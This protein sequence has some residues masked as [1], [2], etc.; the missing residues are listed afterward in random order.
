MLAFFL[1][2]SRYIEYVRNYIYRLK[3]ELPFYKVSLFYIL[4]FELIL[5]SLIQYPEMN[6]YIIFMELGHPILVPVSS[7]FATI[8]L[9]RVYF[10]LK[11]FKH[12]TKWTNSL[13]E[14]IWY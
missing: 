1:I 8:S 4:V 5:L 12:S 6:G 14:Y 11:L 3:N 10:I 7:L 2:I 13:S 9:L